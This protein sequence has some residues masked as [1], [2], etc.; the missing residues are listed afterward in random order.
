MHG[1]ERCVQT[2]AMT[3]ARKH[4]WPQFEQ[5][6]VCMPSQ[7]VVGMGRC[8]SLRWSTRQRR[9]RFSW[10]SRVTKVPARLTSAAGFAE[11][12]AA[13]PLISRSTKP[14]TRHQRTELRHPNWLQSVSISASKRPLKSQTSYKVVL[15]GINRAEQRNHGDNMAPFSS[16]ASSQTSSSWG[17]M[18]GCLR[19]R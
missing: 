6:L 8:V 9:C 16:I 10:R 3:I 14:C 18:G 17:R 4:R 12:L 2:L 15:A 1:R 19:R 13:I 11:E 5:S 7:L